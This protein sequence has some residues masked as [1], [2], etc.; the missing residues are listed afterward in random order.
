MVPEMACSEARS[1]EAPDCA[2]TR[3]EA[4]TTNI[5]LMK[6]RLMT[7]LLKSYD[8]LIQFGTIG[9]EGFLGESVAGGRVRPCTAAA[10]DRDEA[11][12]AALAFVF[13]GVAKL[14]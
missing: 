4:A 2:A 1:Y 11:A 5:V 10:A 12:I 14:L 6:W 7:N 8:S 13:V 3:A 9:A